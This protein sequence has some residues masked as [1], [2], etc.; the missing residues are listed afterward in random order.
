MAHQTSIDKRR[1]GRR[2]LVPRHLLPI[3]KP[4]C[5]AHHKMFVAGRLT[6]RQTPQQRWVVLRLV[7]RAFLCQTDILITELDCFAYDGV[8]IVGITL[9]LTENGPRMALRKACIRENEGMFFN[10]R[11][12][13]SR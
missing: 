3:K 11:V 9:D 6:L 7:I 10:S 2:T 1:R 12:F 8:G 4:A 13:R 5:N